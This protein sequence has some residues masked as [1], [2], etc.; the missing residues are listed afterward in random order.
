[1]ISFSGYDGLIKKVYLHEQEHVFRFW[2]SLI[3]SEKKAL[4]DEL[5]TIDFELLEK[6]YKQE[7]DDSPKNFYPA[8]YIKLPESGDDEKFSEA[9][10]AGE[11]HIKK[12]KVA[13][14]LVAGGQGSRL[15]F[16]GPKGKFP[17]GPVSGKT[18]FHFHAEKIRA[19]E[20]KYGVRIPFLIMTSRDNHEETEAF[21]RAEHFFGLS[22]E[23]VHIFPQN[24]IPSLDLNG[25]LILSDKNKLFMNPDGHGGSLTA[26]RTSGALKLLM[27]QGIET[28]SY[29]QVDNPLVK[30]IDPLFIGFHAMNNA[31]ISSKALMK[32]YHEEKTGIFVE[33]EDGKVGI[34]EYSDMPEDKIFAKD[35]K[36]GILYS[37]ANPA[38]HLF[39]TDFISSIT[40]DGSVSLP[41]HVAKKKI[42]AFDDG[43]Q[44]EITGYKFEKFVFDAL[45]VA[46]KNIILET[47]REEEFA[48]IKNA[49]GADSLQTAQGLMNS[50]YRKWL[51]AKGVKIP[52]C[53]KAIEISPLFALSE[54]DIPEGTIIPDKEM[55][56]LN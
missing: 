20:K 21:F 48:P 26:L 27:D 40:G 11:A 46:E 31:E 2:D 33:F 50:L 52:E 23:F 39:S 42:S 12:G 17:A 18:L 44:N 32:A 45:P 6:I 53:V 9:E 38:I 55:V 47:R 35:E 34:V 41:Y 15:G 5:S 43:G 56:F 51:T 25:K 30:I 4:L 24:M 22:P 28:I 49:S 54:K 8:P 36:G 16:D 3:E 14:F 10:A 19:S 1:M 29:F 7:S 37:A 13:A